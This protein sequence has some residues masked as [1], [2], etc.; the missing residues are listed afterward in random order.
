MSST[1]FPKNTFLHTLHSGENINI[2]NKISNLP[3]Q[4]TVNLSSSTLRSEESLNHNLDIQQYNLKEILELFNINSY[5]F[6]LDD[7]KNAKKKVL[8]MHPDKSNLPHDYFLFYKKA[9]DIVVK[10]Y[11][12]K[13]KTEEEVSHTNKN[14]Q[15]SHVSTSAIN[16]TYDKNIHKKIKDTMKESSVEEYNRNFN[17]LFENMVAKSTSNKNEWFSKDEPS[18]T[19]SST[20]VT[21]SNINNV[22]ETIKKQTKGEVVIH[23]N[24]TE[25]FSFFGESYYEDETENYLNTNYVQCD[26]FSKLKFEDLRKVHKDQTIFDVSEEDFRNVTKYRD[27]NMYKDTRSSQNLVPKTQIENQKIIEEQDR[28]LKE[29]TYKLQHASELKTQQF[30]EKNKNVLSTFLRLRDS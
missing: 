22:F 16:D 19:V 25:M 17:K 8:M 21:P 29:K 11:S 9:F 6:S 12:S 27:V 3:S 28:I 5:D 24:P 13:N 26:P 18:I 23:R 7:L 2:I 10:F 20:I 14:T 30:I 1:S 4:A 15:Y